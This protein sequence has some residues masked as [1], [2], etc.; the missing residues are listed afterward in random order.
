M[1]QLVRVRISDDYPN[2]H[3]RG[4]LGT[5]GGKYPLKSGVA[6]LIRNSSSVSLSTLQIQTLR[7]KHSTLGEMAADNGIANKFFVLF[8]WG[9]WCGPC[10]RQ[11]E[12]AL[13]SFK[14]VPVLFLEVLKPN[15]S[16]PTQV[17]GKNY[18]VFPP[19]SRSVVALKGIPTMILVDP[20]FNIALSTHIFRDIA[21]EYYRLVPKNQEQ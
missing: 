19:E 18:A 20:D 9:T 2:K 3:C 11:K 13:N 21:K 17:T 5:F 15:M 16:E 1:N 8:F 6:F 10:K 12:I 7:G 4:K 14:D